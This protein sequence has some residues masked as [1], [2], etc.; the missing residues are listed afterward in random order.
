MLSKKEEESELTTTTAAA[1]LLCYFIT[2]IKS[3]IQLPKG[4]TASSELDVT[5]SRTTGSATTQI[6]HTYKETL[7]KVNKCINAY[8]HTFKLCVYKYIPIY[9]LTYIHHTNIIMLSEVP[10]LQDG[11]G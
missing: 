4:S 8:I 9:I 5:K 7:Y 1:T 6:I 11:G 3:K 2:L 10:E